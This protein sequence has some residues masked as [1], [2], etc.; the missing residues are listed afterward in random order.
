MA[1]ST[2]PQWSAP[3]EVAWPLRLVAWAALAAVAIWAIARV[4]YLPTNDGPQHV[5]SGVI[6]NHFEDPG[7]AYP[8][9]LIPQVQFAE[10]GFSL[11][12]APLEAL[13]GWRRALVATLAILVLATGAAFAFLARRLARP[14][15]DLAP[16]GLALAFSWPFYMG[17]FA[18]AAA[19]SIG[20]VCIALAL[21]TDRSVRRDA[22]L[23]ALFSFAAF[24]HVIAAAL[25]GIVVAVVRLSTAPRR[26][27]ELFRLVVIGAVPLVVLAL[28]ALTHDDAAR[29]S[30]HEFEWLPLAAWPRELPRLLSPG[31]LARAVLVTAAIVAA[32]AQAAVRWRRLAPAERGV[33]VA[34]A[35]FVAIG[36]LA[37]L[38]VPGWQLFS[39]RWL[40]FVPFLAIP[41]VPLERLARRRL[42]A[43]AIAVASGALLVGSARLHRRLFDGVADAYASLPFAVRTNG[44]RLP[45]VFHPMGALAEDPTAREVPHDNPLYHFGAL[46]AAE[47]GGMIPSM[48]AGSAAV[49]AFRTVGRQP[50]APSV[51]L[52]IAAMTDEPPAAVMSLLTIY[53]IRYDEVELLGAN[54]AHL[55]PFVARGYEVTWSRKSTAIAHFRGCATTL[56]LT[57]PRT[58]ATRVELRVP[59]TD[60]VLWSTLVPAGEGDAAVAVIPPLCG[61]F[62]LRVTR[63]DGARACGDA[64][65]ILRV[66]AR[67]ATRVRCAP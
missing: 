41:L 38:N 66:I 21:D 44:H 35:A 55:A 7:V 8:R 6:Q 42:A 2:P 30:L 67:G 51:D 58:T 18:F 31:P 13:F 3:R 37:P 50:P 25:T 60:D 36:C 5:L 46:Y 10:H 1:A 16:L 61:G 48:F 28:T 26:L 22:L 11:L 65:G 14:R 49:Y 17:F 9:H 29:L 15:V 4:P 32:L 45:L 64:G 54:P 56:D 47:R 34:A 19:T 12:F 57:G 24:A 33:L 23:F 62:T 27:A 40:A 52:A 39:P 59:P 20:L 53:G 63:D 43:A